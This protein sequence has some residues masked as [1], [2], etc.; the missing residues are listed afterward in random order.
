MQHTLNQWVEEEITR[1]NRK[2]LEVNENEDTTYQN[3]GDTAKT[4]LREQLIV[5]N[6]YV[7]K[8]K[9]FKSPSSSTS[10]FWKKK[11]KLNSKQAECNNKED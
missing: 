4:W 7:K 10:K 9:A 2:C 3:L 8:K 5:V 6:A 1:T 11:S